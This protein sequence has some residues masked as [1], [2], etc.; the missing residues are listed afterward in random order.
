MELCLY[1]AFIFQEV[2]HAEVSRT[3]LCMQK[4]QRKDFFPLVKPF[5][6][7][8]RVC[9]PAMAAKKFYAPAARAGAI[10][11]PEDPSRRPQRG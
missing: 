1:C 2:F 3:V 4:K 6:R 11:N 5:F 8:S 10:Q 7:P 9:L